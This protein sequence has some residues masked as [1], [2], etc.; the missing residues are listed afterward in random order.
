LLWFN[1]GDSAAFTIAQIT[2]TGRASTYKLSKP[3]SGR[4]HF[5]G[6]MAVGQDGNLYVL[7][8]VLGNAFATHATLYRVSPSKLPQARA[9]GWP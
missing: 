9:V 2:A 4:Q 8:N 6:S 3:V 1:D 5:G 7:D